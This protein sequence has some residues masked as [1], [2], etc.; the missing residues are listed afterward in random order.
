MTAYSKASQTSRTTI[1]KSQTE[2]N[3]EANQ[4]LDKLYAE[5]GIDYCELQLSKNCLKR[6]KYSNGE[7]LKL[8]YAHKHK[9][10]WYRPANKQ[11]LLWSYKQTIKCCISCHQMIEHND[12]LT[13]IMFK[14]LRNDL[15][16]LEHN[17]EHNKKDG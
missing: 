13:R 8:T 5:K 1:K 17:K 3:R 16:D 14:R 6:E 10:I 15:L 4:R 2:K 12:K 11:H 7:L 9:R